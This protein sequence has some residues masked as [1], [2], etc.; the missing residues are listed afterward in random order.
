LPLEFSSSIERER[1]KVSYGE[2]FGGAPLQD[3]SPLRCPPAG[4]GE[5]ADGP[6]KPNRS[7]TV[8]SDDHV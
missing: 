5:R 6:R 1:L 8:G 7:K 3:F 4:V 2:G